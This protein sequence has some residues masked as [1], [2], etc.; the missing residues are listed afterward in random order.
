[1]KKL[2]MLAVFIL[3]SNLSFAQKGTAFL[4]GGNLRTVFDLA[5]AQNKPVHLEVYAP[6]CHVCNAFKPTFENAQVGNIFNQ[7]FVNYK[8]DITS[9]EGAAFLNKQ[10]IWIP[11]TPTLLFFDKDVKLQHITVLGENY[12]T[13]QALIEAATKAIDP[14]QRTSN[15]KTS[16][17]SGNRD[18][19][20]LIEYGFMARIMRDTV[21]NINV[22]NN[23]AK[24]IPSAQYSNN[25]SFLLLQKVI[26]DDDNDIFEY[27][28]NH[29]GEFN[30]KY[31][32]TLVKQTAENIIMYS[33]YSSRGMRYSVAKINQ[34]RAN[35]AKLGVD[36]KSINGRVWREESTAYF[37]EGQVPKALA[38]LD[39]LVDAKTDKK[40]YKFLSD[41]IKARSADKAALAKAALWDAKSK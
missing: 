26:M 34:V 30:A 35:L 22:M 5:K 12:N 4:Q 23:Y 15:Y 37:R 19:N 40:S 6:T 17:R 32:K 18:A 39:S 14:K 25:T 38:V 21:D 33:L 24:I 29:L 9:P 20:F 27:M 1:M 8:L 10:G 13:P 28:I 36:K 41:W 16:Y 2:L 11:S 7:N 3:L 31:D